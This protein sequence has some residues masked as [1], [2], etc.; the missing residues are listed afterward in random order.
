MLAGG[1]AHDFNNILTVILSC[2]EQLEADAAAGRAGPEEVREIHAA[3][4]R[5]RDYA[6]LEG[7]YDKISSIGMYEHVGI[8]NYPKYFVSYLKSMFGDAAKPRLRECADAI[9]DR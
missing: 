6:T 3:A 2:A 9:T 7:T 5:A 4:D 1:I 8:A